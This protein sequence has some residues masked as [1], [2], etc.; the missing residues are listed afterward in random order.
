SGRILHSFDVSASKYIPA[1]YPYIVIAN[2]AG[3]KAWVSLWNASAVV[4]LD[5]RTKKVTRRI[6][7]WRPSDPVAPGTHPT[8]MLLNLSEDTLYVAMAN[9]GMAK[10]DGV[11]AVDLKRGVPRGCYRVALAGNSEPGAAS[12]AIALS[13]DEK[14]LY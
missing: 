13:A 1:A 6:E 10:T 5:L 8:A 2:K 12:I 3:T 9:A 7:L 4:E 14:H 11:A